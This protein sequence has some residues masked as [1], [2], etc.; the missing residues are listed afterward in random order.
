[1]RK[2][3][4]EGDFFQLTLAPVFKHSEVVEPGVP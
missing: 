2:H 3:P 4:C 1:L